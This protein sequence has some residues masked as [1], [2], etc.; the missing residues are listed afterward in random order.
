[1][2]HVTFPLQIGIADMCYNQ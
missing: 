2:L 1:M